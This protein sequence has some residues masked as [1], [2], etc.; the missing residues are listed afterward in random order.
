MGIIIID[1]KLTNMVL[2]ENMREFKTKL[3]DDLAANTK[4]I[5]GKNTPKQKGYASKNYR[6]IKSLNTR[7]IKNDEYYLP[8]VNDGTGLYGPLHHR[9]KPKRA[10]VLHFY[11]HGKEWY[12]KSV[13][14]Q[15]GQHFVERSMSEVIK[16]IDNVVVN[17]SR[18]TLK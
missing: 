4:T 3:L 15:K 8:W 1:V 5:F 7:E 12:L 10:R 16:S 9:I 2:A 11:W 17:A 14:G 6:I 13:R 18:G